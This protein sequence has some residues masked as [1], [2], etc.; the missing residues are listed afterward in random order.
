M[1]IQ[2]HTAEFL[3]HAEGRIKDVLEVAGSMVEGTAVELC[4]YDTGY[5]RGS[6]THELR[7]LS[8]FVGSPVFYAPYV[9][10]GTSRMAARSYLVAAIARD[11]VRIQRLFREKT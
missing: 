8:V 5:L 9:E 1:R 3:R 10:L 7:G 11:R 4:P 2:D 6:L